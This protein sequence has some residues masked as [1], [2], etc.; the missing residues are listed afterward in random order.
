MEG[1]WK[2]VFV[3]FPTGP[4][5]P[6]SGRIGPLSQQ[7]P[8]LVYLLRPSL[9]QGFTWFFFPPKKWPREG[10]DLLLASIQ[11][12]L[13]FLISLPLSPIAGS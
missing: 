4:P 12:T 3:W 13:S 6:W 9:V 8:W 2:G 10:A 7:N 1:H 5:F 11:P